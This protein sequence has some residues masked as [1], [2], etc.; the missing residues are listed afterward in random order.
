MLATETTESFLVASSRGSKRDPTAGCFSA[1][2][3]SAALSLSLE[4]G[5]VVFSSV[6]VAASA[7]LNESSTT[8]TQSACVS[9]AP[10]LCVSSKSLEFTST[11]TSKTFPKGESF[12]AKAC[13]AV[14]SLIEA[15]SLFSIAVAAAVSFI[16][17]AIVTGSVT[18][19][20]GC[21]SSE[22]AAFTS[23]ASKTDSK[24]GSL[25]GGVSSKVSL[26]M[27]TGTIMFFSIKVA[28]FVSF[29]GLATAVAR[30][31]CV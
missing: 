24:T 27:Q 20:P 29:T 1:R 9:P 2:V 15:V 19:Q 13:S 23:P 8:A 10:S 30:S 6:E 14:S 26:L 5:T 28:L 25:S 22:S 16:A 3:F 21:T 4:A 12:R 31:F 11:P 17:S 18:V 7:S